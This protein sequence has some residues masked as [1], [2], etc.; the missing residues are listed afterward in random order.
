MTIVR[1][2]DRPD[3]RPVANLLVRTFQ[4]RDEPATQEMADYLGQLLL[5]LPDRDPEINSLVHV[6]DDGQVNGFIGVFTQLMEVDGRVLRAAMGNSF[7]VDPGA[8][9]PM[10][11]AR[12]LRAYFR[13]PQDIT[14]SDRCNA[15]SVSMWR[16]MGGSS[17]PTYSMEWRRTL[18]PVSA[19][20]SRVRS[21]LKLRRATAP[22]TSALDGVVQRYARRRGKPQW[23]TP[24]LP[25]RPPGLSRRDA[26]DADL[27]TAIPELVSQSRL[28]PVWSE[29]GLQTLLA[30]SARKSELGE[31]VRQVIHDRSGR[32][33]GAYL[34]YVE[35]HGFAQVLHV[36]SAKGMAEPV[37]DILLADA[38]ERGAVAIGGRAQA[39]LLEPLMDRHAVLS[40]EYRCVFGASD[41]A[42]L[43]AVSRGDA[44]VGGMVGEL[45]TRLNGDGLN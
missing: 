41:P 14:I 19:A 10:I 18:R 33:V 8:H 9:D 11:G 43:D 13:G 12:L 21:R 3:L 15:I 5:D 36:L 29:A 24:T 6:D 23:E 4:E 25:L 44:V 37:L 40:G 16:G 7:A 42:V 28:H 22:L 20:T 35:A 34:Y 1:P 31:T 27:L 2:L 38:A 39:N 30:H 32:L 45:W 17:L 26:T